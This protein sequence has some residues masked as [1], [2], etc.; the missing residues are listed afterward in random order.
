MTPYDGTATEPRAISKAAFRC[1][2]FV[3]M[4]LLAVTEAVAASAVGWALGFRIEGGWIGGLAFL[5]LV[6]S[7][8]AVD[9][10]LK[11]FGLSRSGKTLEVR[12]R[13]VAFPEGE[14]ADDEVVQV[15][16]PPS[17]LTGLS[18]ACLMCCLL[19]A[20]I[21]VAVPH[22]RMEGV[23]WAYALIAFFGL[24]A[25]YCLYAGRRGRPQA[26]ADASGI[27]GYPVGFH[28]R[29]RSVPWSAV[30]TCEIETYH[31]TFGKPVIVRPTFKGCDGEA[32]LTLNL[33]STTMEDQERLVKYIN[34]KVPKPK[35]DFWE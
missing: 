2:V 21:L 17:F 35:E 23:G 18:V 20:L 1:L 24:V 29:R 4:V 13:T 32:L 12:G 31:D 16:C 15:R 28:A 6:L 33:L 26:W 27:T 34:A 14:V 19:I 22:G 3:T 25:G 9:G 30:A 11:R 8:V 5:N 10:I 7:R